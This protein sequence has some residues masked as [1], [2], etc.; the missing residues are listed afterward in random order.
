MFHFNCLYNV[1]I[2]NYFSFS[3]SKITVFIFY[4]FIFYIFISCNKCFYDLSFSL[5]IN[6]NNYNADTN[7][8]YTHNYIN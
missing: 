8:I 3:I 4:I 2:F 1:Y 5:V 6:Y 7:Y